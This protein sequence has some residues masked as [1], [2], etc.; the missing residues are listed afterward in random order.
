[1]NCWKSYE[2]S[3]DDGTFGDVIYEWVK[4]ETEEK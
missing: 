1:M 4:E 3:C 2:V